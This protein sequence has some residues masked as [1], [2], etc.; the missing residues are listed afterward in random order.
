MLMSCIILY[1]GLC[2]PSNA[3]KFIAIL[4]YLISY[5]TLMQLYCRDSACRQPLCCSR[6][7]KVTHVSINQKLICDLV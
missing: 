6:S 1:T 3:R 7:F 5:K 2:Q 4:C